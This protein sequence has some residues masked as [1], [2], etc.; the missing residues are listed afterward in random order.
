MVF[1][2]SIPRIFSKTMHFCTVTLAI[3]GVIT[4]PFESIYYSG[5]LVP[6]ALAPISFLVAFSISYL[7]GEKIDGQ[8]AVVVLLLS[9]LVS[10]MGFFIINR[11][12]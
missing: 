2:V 5:M 7:K 12:T 8:S 3:L 9:F 1:E 10:A 6:I 4:R 11:I